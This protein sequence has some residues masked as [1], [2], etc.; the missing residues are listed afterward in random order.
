M[1]TRDLTIVG[2][3]QSE[4]DTIAADVATELG[5]IL[6]PDPEPEKGFYYRSDHFSFAKVGIPAFYA[7]PGV[8]YLDKPTDYG[9]GKRTEYTTNDYHKVSD[10]VKPDW[11]LS[12]ALEDLTFLF[13]MGAR[14]ASSEAWPAWSASSEFAAIRE[15]QRPQ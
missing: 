7:D 15:L 1:G 3:G 8:E 9:I 14:L 4:L 2:L 6:G 12:G 10:E 5:R 11:D 13:H